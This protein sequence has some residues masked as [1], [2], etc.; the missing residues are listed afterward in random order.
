M[1]TKAQRAH[2]KLT[3][4]AYHEAGHAIAMLHFQLPFRLVSILPEGDSLGRVIPGK[5]DDP[6]TMEFFDDWLEG[7]DLYK[8]ELVQ[9]YVEPLHQLYDTLADMTG[10]LAEKKVTGRYN[11]VGADSDHHN[12]ADMALHWAGGAGAEANAYVKWLQLRAQAFIDWDLRWLQI[13]R[14]AEALLERKE[15]TFKEAYAV[16]VAASGELMQQMIQARSHIT[17]TTTPPARPPARR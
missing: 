11:Y 7:M 3:A 16:F 17:E 15:L 4:V 10:A 1:T 6:G 9:E 2:K 5:P 8:Q 14:L 13:Q 12:I